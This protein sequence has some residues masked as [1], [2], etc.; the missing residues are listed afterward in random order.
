MDSGEEYVAVNTRLPR[1]DSD[2]FWARLRDLL[3][4]KGIDPARAGLATCFPDDRDFEFG[5]IASADGGGLR[6]RLRLP[7]QAG[8]RGRDDRMM[9]DHR[10]LARST[11]QR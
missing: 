8:G 9:P 7:G 4:A 5:I 10:R 2:P 11:V 3:R 6:V 1:G